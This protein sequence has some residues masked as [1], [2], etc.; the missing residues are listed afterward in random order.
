[1]V[2]PDRCAIRQ[3]PKSR[4]C[5]MITWALIAMFAAGGEP[6]LIGTYKTEE[7]CRQKAQISEMLYSGAERQIECFKLVERE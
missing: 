3:N 5:E 6:E 2:D 1:M 7:E 4:G